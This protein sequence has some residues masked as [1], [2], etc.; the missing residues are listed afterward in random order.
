L[1][2]SFTD[3]F[4]RQLWG[5][6][7]SETISGPGSTL[8]YTEKLR[9]L[10]PTL[11]STLGCARLL[12]APCGD[13]NWMRAVPLPGV[14]YQGADIVPEIVET[15]R[16]RYPA[17]AFT[18]LDITADPLP[19]V[20]FWL[21]RDVLLHM[22]DDAIRLKEFI[23]SRDASDYLAANAGL[24]T[25]LGRPEADFLWRY[26]SP[27]AAATR[28]S[29][30]KHYLKFVSV[31]Y[32]QSTGVADLRVQGFRPAD[33]QQ[34]A[35]ALMA[36][37]E[38][39]INGLNERS[40]ADAVKSALAE[41][42]QAERRAHKALAAVTEFR[43]REKV[44]DPAQASLAA[45]NTIASLSLTTAEANASLI[46]AAKA[47]PGSP[48]VATLSRKIAALQDQIAV[49]RSKLAGGSDSLAPR[50]AEYEG[51]ILDQ[52]F[53]EKAFLSALTALETARIDAQRQ[54]VFLES[55]SSAD[56]PDYAAYP[57]RALWILVVFA[58][59]L[60]CWRIVRTLVADTRSHTAS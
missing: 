19:P 28:E 13:F 56:L 3:A 22:S 30:F 31:D 41:V 57:H 44:I 33:A 43:S 35:Q 34:I 48:Q 9:A 39:L 17:I 37:A 60:L 51:L 42:E 46:D 16:E 38:L 29:L 10:L 12:D 20:D 24:L 7:D 14:A 50:L 58:T 11:L 40:G 4:K 15:L 55:V 45:L 2:P 49:E 21:C 52:T 54:R 8:R 26:P 6:S 53:A 1:Q 32:D 27:F 36:R 25:V 5:L 18:C 23:L 47:T 59:G